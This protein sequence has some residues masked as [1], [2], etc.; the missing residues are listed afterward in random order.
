MLGYTGGGSTAH[1]YYSQQPSASFGTI[2]T[3]NGLRFTAGQWAGVDRVQVL[4]F[5]GDGKSDLMLIK[6]YECEIIT[7]DGYQARR[8]YYSSNN[9]FLN[10][11]CLFYPGDFNGD[12]KTDLLVKNKITGL[13]KILIATGKNY[14]ETA[15]TFN[16]TPDTDPY[17]GDQLSIA[18]F[19][20]DGKSDIYHGWQVSSGNASMDVYYGTGF[21]E[22]PQATN[23]IRN[24]QT[25]SGNLGTSP[26][27]GNLGAIPLFVGDA[28][29][30]GRAD[31]INFRDIYTPMDIFY[32]R[33]EGTENLLANVKNGYGH[34]IRFNYKKLTDQA[35]FYTQGPLTAY[36]LLTMQ[37]PIY[38]VSEQRAQNGL[39]SENT[40]QYTYA[41]L[42]L[43]RAGK[44]FLGFTTVTANDLA[45]GIK[46]IATNQFNT[47]FY[48]A[49]P[50]RPVRIY[51]LPTRCSAKLPSP[52]SGSIWATNASGSA[53][54]APIPTTPLKAAPPATAWSMMPTAT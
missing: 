6:D 9:Q 30:D 51:P 10:Q 20:G 31:L 7:L 38:A 22:T 13:W 1:I 19:N 32:F 29:G 41:G 48:S 23:F 39:L 43:H 4:D 34:E 21:T 54:T 16:H 50:Y 15:F 24:N 26:N 14:L 36:P 49:A 37:L 12:Q 47:T 40:I 8:L 27:P 35:S 3:S 11:N 2:G 28:N 44:G 42:K 33:K 52:T 17:T 18:D 5:N 25:W 45:T 46:T 53:P